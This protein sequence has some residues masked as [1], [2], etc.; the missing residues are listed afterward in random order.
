MVDEL[1]GGL[2]MR[3]PHAGDQRRV[4]ERYASLCAAKDVPYASVFTA[5]AEQPS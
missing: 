5:P 3:H 4:L 1:P 2:V